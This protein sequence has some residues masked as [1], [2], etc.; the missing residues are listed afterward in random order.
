MNDTLKT[1]AERAGDRN[2]LDALRYG[3]RPDRFLS[4]DFAE[5]VCLNVVGYYAWEEL[6]PLG[7]ASLVVDFMDTYGTAYLAAFYGETVP[8]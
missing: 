1:I 4:I 3:L 7:R 2:A 8:S 6:S 5:N